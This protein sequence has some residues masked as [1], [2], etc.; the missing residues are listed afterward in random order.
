[1][2]QG[3]K[4]FIIILAV[5]IIFINIY[6][7]FIT[8]KEKNS[9]VNVKNFEEKADIY[10][11]DILQNSNLAD[12]K[13]TDSEVWYYVHVC[14]AVVSPG[15]YM[16]KEG[17]RI[18]DA[19]AAAGGFTDSAVQDYHNLAKRITDEQ[20]IYVPDIYEYDLQN[21]NDLCRTDI[22]KDAYGRININ[23]AGKQVLMEL[24]GIGEKKAENIIAYREKHGL[25]SDKSELKDVDGISDLLY[26]KIKDNITV[27]SD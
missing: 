19:I 5:A 4:I 12:D 20:Q 24:D 25:F 14:G 3:K 1:M 18:Q 9:E 21:N 27:S 6:Y 2:K 17:S 16:L 22:Q 11:S 8:K 10:I 23:T 13:Y 15:V 7:F 26:E